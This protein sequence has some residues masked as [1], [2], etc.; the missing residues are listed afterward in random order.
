MLLPVF[1]QVPLPKVEVL[2]LLAILEVKPRVATPDA[3]D[4]VDK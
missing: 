2:V 4:D 3:A 1:L